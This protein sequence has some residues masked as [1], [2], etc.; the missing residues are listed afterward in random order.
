MPSCGSCTTV[1]PVNNK[2]FRENTLRFQDRKG[3]Y[4]CKASPFTSAFIDARLLAG[5]V[6][7]APCGCKKHRAALWAMWVGYCDVID[8]IAT[9]RSAATH[10]TG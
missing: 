9:T 6:G 4:S 3:A 7:Q 10:V 5:N 8:S 2:N 1:C